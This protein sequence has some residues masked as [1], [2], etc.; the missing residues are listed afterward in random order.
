MSILTCAQPCKHKL[1]D[2]QQD[3]VEEFSGDGKSLLLADE[4]GLGKTVQSLLIVREQSLYPCLILVPKSL[5][6][7]WLGEVKH[8]TGKI[9]IL[10]EEEND[11]GLDTFL[12]NPREALQGIFIVHHD[13]LSQI[14][15]KPWL[16]IMYK[17][18]WKSV[19]VD[20]AHKFRNYDTKRGA[21][22]L[23]F[24]NTQRWF[25][26]TGTPVI[27]TTLDL[28]PMTRLLRPERPEFQTP[29]GF[30]SQF[31]TTQM[32]PQGM[33][34]IDSKNEDHLFSLI[35]NHYIRREKQE[36]LKD[37][38]PKIS[39]TLHLQLDAEQNAMYQHFEQYLSMLL[40]SG[41]ELYSPNVLSSLMRLRQISLDPRILGRNVKG[42]KTQA[43]LDLIESAPHKIVVFSTLAQFLNILSNELKQR[44]IQHLLVTGSEDASSNSIRFNRSNLYK[45]Y[46][47]TMQ[48]GLGID[49]ITAGTVVITDHWWNRAAE[50]QAIDRLHRIGQIHDSVQVITLH[51]NETIDDYLETVLAR[52]DQMVEKITVEREVVKAIRDKW[53]T[54]H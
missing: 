47:S 14:E 54:K 32:T 53:K 34:V 38:P 50:A 35:S 41:E 49:L 3:C 23:K 21:T 27:N 13:V 37:L 6:L 16:E 17:L 40:D 11:H 28:Y 30:I 46:L 44:K 51:A 5:R 36:V 8:W 19:I 20:E 10:N 42:A 29:G 33:E 18:S 4:M 43:I 25:F 7:K 2:F 31:C 9:A 12:S 24:K 1:Y 26:L 48:K 22:L 45:V 15:R 39:T 52:K